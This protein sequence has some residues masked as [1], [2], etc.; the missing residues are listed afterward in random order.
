MLNGVYPIMHAVQHV[1]MAAVLVHVSNIHHKFANS[2]KISFREFLAY[3]SKFPVT[4]KNSYCFESVWGCDS[5]SHFI[6][7]G[8]CKLL[9]NGLF[10][11]Q[12][13]KCS[14]KAW[15]IFRVV[16]GPQV[17]LTVRWWKEMWQVSAKNQRSNLVP[18]PGKRDELYFAHNHSNFH[19]REL[20]SFQTLG[21]DFER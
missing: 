2:N 14:L 5:S 17:T 11:A 6:A 19:P 1:S 10:P 7:Q 8:V 18:K 13:N 20:R 15:A 12:V 3:L 16:Q 21:L 4:K 9:R